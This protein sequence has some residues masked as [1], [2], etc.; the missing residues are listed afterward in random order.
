MENLN[1]AQPP[2]T[3]TAPI[4]EIKNLKTY[5]FL[6]KSTVRSLDGVNLTL[7]RKTTLGLVGESGCGKSVMAMS[8]MRLIQ[9][10]PGKIVEG[11]I[12]LHRKATGEVIDIAKLSPTGSEMRHIRGGE[13]AI[14]FQEPMMSLNPLYTVGAQIAEVVQLHQKVSRKDAM[15]RALEM[16]TRVQISA[17]KQRLNEY[18]HQLSG[19]MRQRVMIALALSCNP[20]ILIADEPTTALDVTVQSQILD[21]MNELQADFDASII[22]ITHNLGVVS[23]MAQQVA[24]MYLG[25]IVEYTD[26]RELFHNPKHPYT[27]GLLNSV[28]VLGK[29][30]EKNLVPIKGMVPMPTEKIPGCAFAPRCP[31]VMS[32]CHHKQ[33]VLKEVTPD[34]Q[35]ACW[36]YD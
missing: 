32:I 30:G 35:T 3:T 33:P 4:L 27:V 11:E 13:I 17:P 16:L 23:Q 6:E 24:V 18:P 31:R 22:L 1:L 19:G 36:L 20:S 5:F 9:S 15:D 14:V 12:N 25:K 7:P 8:V 26:T 34:H 10:P 2:Q 29:K 21:L 28:P